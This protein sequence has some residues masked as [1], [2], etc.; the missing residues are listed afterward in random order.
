M[1]WIEWV[2]IVWFMRS[3]VMTTFK[4]I[5]RGGCA[6]IQRWF[7]QASHVV[8]HAFRQSRV[9]WVLKVRIALHHWTLHWKKLLRSWRACSNISGMY[10]TADLSCFKSIWRSW[11][12]RDH[13]ST[14]W[15]W[16]APDDSSC[17]GSIG[18]KAY[19]RSLAWAWCH[20]TGPLWW[21][22]LTSMERQTARRPTA[23]Y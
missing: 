6:V 16:P 9:D 2:L 18:S 11:A 13:E 1:I 15:S 23:T 20:W 14:R 4:A 21:K 8:V 17:S 7:R 3:I 10:D 5:L 19:S 22:L 12:R